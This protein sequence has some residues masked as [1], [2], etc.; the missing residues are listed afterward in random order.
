M[1]GQTH[2]FCLDPTT[3]T[4]DNEIF[5]LRYFGKGRERE[6]KSMQV[7]VINYL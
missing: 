3:D 1:I 5:A 2:G 4:L 7:T 6:K